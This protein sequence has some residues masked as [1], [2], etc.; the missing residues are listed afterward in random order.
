[1]SGS[2]QPM[3]PIWLTQ[4]VQLL[5]VIG[6]TGPM[7]VVTKVVLL[8]QSD[9]SQIHQDYNV[10]DV[11]FMKVYDT[12]EGRIPTFKLDPATGLTEAQF[13]QEISDLNA[14]GRSV[15]IALGGA[16]AHIE[17]VT[18][19]ERAAE[20][21][22]LTDKYG[23][24]GLDIDLEQSAVTAANNQTVI[25]AALRMVKDHYRKQGKNFLITMAAEFPYPTTGGKYLPYITGLEGYYDWIN[26]SFTIR[27]VTVFMLKAQALAGLPRT[28]MRRKKQLI[29]YISDSH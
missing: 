1:M 4:R 2:L 13:I 24:D 19:D 20:L 9:L 3:A 21:I 29:Y 16:D 15:L 17:L 8:L 23:F 10:I 27:V 28:T 26:L 7:V 14:Q 6:I 18:G 11:S 12:A 22:R 5:S 25:P